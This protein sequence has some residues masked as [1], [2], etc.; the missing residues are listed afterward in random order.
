MVQNRKT[1]LESD[2][3]LSVYFQELGE[4]SRQVGRQKRQARL[5]NIQ[6]AKKARVQEDQQP[7]TPNELEHPRT[8]SQNHLGENR[9]ILADVGSLALKNCV[10]CNEGLLDFSKITEEHDPM[11]LKVICQSCECVN[12]INLLSNQNLV[13]ENESHGRKQNPLARRAVLGCLHQ[14]LGHSHYESLMVAMNVQPGRK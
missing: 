12:S 10:E 9:I 3:Q 2:D 1:V 13:H 4:K 6:P 5:K 7:A 11:Y 8:R 14:R